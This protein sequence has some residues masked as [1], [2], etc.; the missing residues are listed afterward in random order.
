MSMKEKYFLKE[1]VSKIK[2][3]NYS[4]SEE[5]I[6]SLS[7]GLAAAFSI[8]G[9]ILLIVKASHESVLNL[10]S[11]TIFG[12]TMIIL[13][14]ISCIYHALSPHIMGKKILRVIDHINV[15]LLVLGTIIPVALIGIGGI[16]GYIFFGIVALV[17]LVGIFASSVNIDKVQWIEVMCHLI[18]G[19]SVLF[20]DKP[21]IANIGF[22]PVLLIIL[23]GVMYSLGAILYGVGSKKKYIHCVFH[24][25]CIF[26]TIFHFIAIYGYLI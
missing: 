17:T 25:F 26:G 5:I 7:H 2:I 1:E 20:F 4:L 12:T 9:L 24:F 15:F 13:Y 14:T 22:M 18:N 11:V 16:K 3:P 6:N 19:W 8:A 21:L 10:V 23:G